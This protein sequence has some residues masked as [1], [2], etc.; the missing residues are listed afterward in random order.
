M[1]TT[2]LAVFLTYLKRAFQC[3]STAIKKSNM[4]TTEYVETALHTDRTAPSKASP[5]LTIAFSN[6]HSREHTKELLQVQESTHDPIMS[7]YVATIQVVSI[8]IFAKLQLVWLFFCLKT[9]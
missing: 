4:K 6:A 9:L 1:K 2:C 7:A 8:I 3:A 5:D